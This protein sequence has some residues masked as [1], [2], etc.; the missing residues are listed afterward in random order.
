MHSSMFT[1]NKE[2]KNNF[3]F[4]FFDRQNSKDFCTIDKKSDISEYVSAE[5]L[6]PYELFRR[7]FYI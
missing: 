6:Y 3:Q 1:R 7:F 2:I 5:K 4:D